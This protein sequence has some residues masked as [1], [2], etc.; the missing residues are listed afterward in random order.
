MKEVS[1]ITGYKI[2][3]GGRFVPKL[4]DNHSKHNSY[5]IDLLHNISNFINCI[6]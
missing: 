4:P 6:F 5:E 3:K 2:P 1:Q